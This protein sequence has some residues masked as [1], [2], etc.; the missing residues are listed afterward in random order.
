M[1]Y[2][3]G[4]ITRNYIDLTIRGTTIPTNNDQYYPSVTR[5]SAHSRSAFFEIPA[6]RIVAVRRTPVTNMDDNNNDD[7][8]DIETDSEYDS[9][10]D[11]D[12][13]NRE[14]N[15]EEEDKIAGKCYIGIAYLDKE[16]DIYLMNGTISVRSF[17][18]FEYSRIQAYTR[19]ISLYYVS[20]RPELN[21]LKL[22]IHP[23][24]V[25]EVT[26]HTY[27]IRIIQRAWRKV[28]SRRKHLIRLR[29]NVCNQE[30]FRNNGRYIH[31]T[32][33]LPTI[34]S[35]LVRLSIEGH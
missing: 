11:I 4:R 12:I 24:G 25:Y 13:S 15:Y 10:D 16:H 34:R 23:N 22:H 3:L 28:Y 32:R 1:C 8:S 9:D 19:S 14:V 31:G 33:V 26:I 20:P 35:M 29:G 21:I 2:Y 7:E 17:F 30:Y 27:W 5:P 18:E 6:T